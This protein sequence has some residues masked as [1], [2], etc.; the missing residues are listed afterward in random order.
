[1]T[2]ARKKPANAQRTY[3]LLVGKVEDGRLKLAGNSPHYEVWIKAAG[4]NFRVAVNVRSVDGSNVLVHYDPK[5]TKPT[6]LHLPAVA[7]GAEG[8]RNLATGPHGAGLDYLRDDLFNIND[9][10]PIPADGVGV[11]LHNLLD[12]QIGRAKADG[13]AVAII[14]G[15]FFSDKGSDDTFGFSPEKGVHDIHMMQGN[16]G[17]F[18]NDNR[19]NGDGALFIRFA[20]GETAALFVRFDTQALS[21]DDHGMPTK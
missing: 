21:T 17:S 11:T 15:E 7:A 6:K 18:A 13:G 1:M 10:H 19:I 20:S 14:L 9:M 2:H 5:F 16:R 12:A 4:Q 8:F 3:G